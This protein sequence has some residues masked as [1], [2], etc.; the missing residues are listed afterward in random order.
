MNKLLEL[1]LRKR[2]GADD[3]DNQPSGNAVETRSTDQ[4]TELTTARA[5]SM[6]TSTA[7]SVAAGRRA[8]RREHRGRTP[9]AP[10]GPGR[11]TAPR[12]SIRAS[13]G[14]DLG[15]EVPYARSECRR[16]APD[17]R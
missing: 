5:E 4:D 1:Q 7:S 11:P 3:G 6:R 12:L 13:R 2:G 17:G 8:S 10:H 15:C 9:G 14:E 16:S